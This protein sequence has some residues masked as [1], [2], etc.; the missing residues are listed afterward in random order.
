MRRRG[1]AGR[2]EPRRLIQPRA[3]EPARGRRPHARGQAFARARAC[4]LTPRP[5]PADYCWDPDGGRWEPIPLWA[6]AAA[7]AIMVAVILLVGGGSALATRWA[8]G[9][10]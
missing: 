9:V 6:E 5:R 4:R 10:G 2:V 7:V 3:T 1:R 8:V